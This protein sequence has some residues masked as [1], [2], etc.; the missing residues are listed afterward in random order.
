M[1][2]PIVAAQAVN[3]QQTN[4]EGEFTAPNPPTKMSHMPAWCASMGIGEAL[5]ADFLEN[6]QDMM[7]AFKE[8]GLSEEDFTNI[9]RGFMVQAT[10]GLA[11]SAESMAELN[12]DEGCAGT[13]VFKK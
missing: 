4:E 1:A 7:T 12:D 6:D 10:K 3:V 9:W 11:E 13:A 2:D 8:S 5:A